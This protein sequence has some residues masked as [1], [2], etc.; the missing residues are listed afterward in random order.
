MAQ[1]ASNDI[2]SPSLH[3]INY[4]FNFF[5]KNP[6]Y[7]FEN[8]TNTIILKNGQMSCLYKK[9]TCQRICS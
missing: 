6:E 5:Q 2:Q 8:D 1:V 3:L 7:I 9:S 4:Q